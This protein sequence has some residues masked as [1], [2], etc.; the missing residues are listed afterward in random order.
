[1]CEWETFEGR[2][3]FLDK[4]H[5]KGHVVGKKMVYERKKKKYVRNI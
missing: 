5:R 1:M 4:V 2:E 3:K